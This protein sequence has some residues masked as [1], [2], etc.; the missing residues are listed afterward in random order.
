M[1]ME[2][3]KRSTMS[4][5]LS[6]KTFTLE[7]FLNTKLL[8]SAKL[9]DTSSVSSAAS[10]LLIA[11]F[12]VATCTKSSVECSTVYTAATRNAE[13]IGKDRGLRRACQ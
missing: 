3:L 6:W 10:A 8:I 13:I 12:S 5:Q 1:K 7:N 11:T 2:S 9:L 4:W